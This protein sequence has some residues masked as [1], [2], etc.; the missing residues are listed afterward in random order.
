VLCLSD[1]HIGELVD[2]ATVNGRNKYNP[3]IAVVSLERFFQNSLRLLEAQRV[4]VDISQALLWLGGDLI[5]GYLHEEQVESNPLSPTEEMLLAQPKLVAGI[6]FLLERGGIEKLTV[7]CNYGNHGRTTKKP[8][9]ST[10]AKNSFEWLMYHN[11][12]RHYA[13][14][15]RVDF[16]VASGSHVYVDVLGSMCRFTHGD[17]VRYSG[18]VGGLSIPLRKAIDSWDSFRKARYTFLGHWHQRVD[19]G[20]AV[21][22]GSV[23]GYNAYALHIKAR[24]EEPQQAFVLIDKDH[25]K[26]IS[27]PVFVR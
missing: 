22:N 21:V 8:R 13:K 24:Y 14:E 2:P 5:T 26:T 9:I 11:L 1:L 3:D 15:E 12:R 4:T 23:I 20:F 7:V 10:G 16:V 6:D 19:Y 25:G 27:A 18:G 17:S